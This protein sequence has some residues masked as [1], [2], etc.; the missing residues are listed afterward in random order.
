MAEE[1]N[2]FSFNRADVEM[3]TITYGWEDS[4][5]AWVDDASWLNVLFDIVFKEE[6]SFRDCVETQ[7]KQEVNV[8]IS[9]T[10]SGLENSIMLYFCYGDYIYFHDSASGKYYVSNFAVMNTTSLSAF[11]SEWLKIQ[12]AK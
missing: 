1:E 8:D 7:W 9:L 4:N 5:I 11:K 12:R 2:V 3:A 6:I 10:G